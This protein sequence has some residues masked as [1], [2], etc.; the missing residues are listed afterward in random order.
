MRV[1][2][3]LS[4]RLDCR[5]R[6]IVDFYRSVFGASDSE[7]VSA[8]GRVFSKRVSL[9]V[10]RRS[11]GDLNEEFIILHFGQSVVPLTRLPDKVF[12][13]CELHRFAI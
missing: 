1:P 9:T 4:S 7:T 6:Q 2:V 13:L 8:T 11:V 12:G 3:W 5:D 10:E